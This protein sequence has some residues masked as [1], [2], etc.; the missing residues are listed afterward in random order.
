LVWEEEQLFAES[1]EAWAN[2]PVVP[3][4]YQEHRGKFKVSKW[5]RGKPTRLK[6][7]EKGTVDRVLQYYG[8]KPSQWLSDLTHQEDPWR[9]ARIGLAPGERG[10][11]EI[12]LAAMAEYYSSL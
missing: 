2:G 9:E 3:A 10:D 5:P 1:I 11:R 4:L 6:H 12:G 7:K 8:D